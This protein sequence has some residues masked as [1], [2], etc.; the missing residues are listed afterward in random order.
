MLQVQIRTSRQKWAHTVS[1]AERHI[2]LESEHKA[3]AS[4]Q[5]FKPGQDEASNNHWN[6]SGTNGVDARG[7]K[8]GKKTQPKNRS[9]QELICVLLEG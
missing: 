1:S 6:S 5:A 9:T 2:L 8:W 7:M 3:N 4:G